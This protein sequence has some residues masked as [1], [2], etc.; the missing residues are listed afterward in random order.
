MRILLSLLLSA[1]MI[2]Q[3]ADI[4]LRSNVQL[5]VAP[6]VITDRHGNF[7]RGL[8]AD[9]LVLYDN[10]VPVKIH[11]DDEGLP[12]S[13]VLAIQTTLSARDVL[14]KL[15]NQTSLI[16][17]LLTGQEGDAAV[18]AFADAPYVIQPFSAD[19]AVVEDRIENLEVTGDGGSSIDAV[20]KALSLLSRR[21][22]DRRRVVLLL[23]ERHDR[24]S[25]T[26]LDQAIN[27]AQLA[28]V[29]VYAVTFSPFLAPF[30]NR[31]PMPATSDMNLT[32]VFAEM[33]HAGQKDVGAAFAGATGGREFSFV[34]QKGLEEAVEKIGADLHGQYL[35]SFQ[36][37]N[38]RPNEFHR[39]KIAVRGHPDYNV[40]TRLGYWSP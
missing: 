9:D 38:L 16:A 30:T 23:S 13:F 2:A 39:I 40:R 20:V 4:P 32:G 15:H 26:K 10:N 8:T 14:E 1:M 33:K 5:V 37:Q 24:T 6:T 28:N 18:I 31:E 36:P 3:T 25:K 21:H 34:R 7:I 35:V 11:M 19:A 17:P 22:G 29:T 12:I 27:A